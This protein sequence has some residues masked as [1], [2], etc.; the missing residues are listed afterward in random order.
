MQIGNSVSNRDTV[1]QLMK[2]LDPDGVSERRKRRLK[3]R[4]YF[5]KVTI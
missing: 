1:M 2:E 3:R 5:S 4:Q